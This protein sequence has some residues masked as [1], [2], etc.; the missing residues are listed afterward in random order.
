MSNW[1]PSFSALRAFDATARHLNF[2][3]A[4]E[5]LSVTPSAVKQ[6]VRKLEDSLGQPLVERDGRGLR[7][8]AAGEAGARRISEGFSS[9]AAGVAAIRAHDERQRL[10]LTVEPSFAATW[11]VPRLDRFR[12]VCPDVD[13]LVDSSPALV[14]LTK[15]TVD[16]A[17]RFSRAAP[18]GLVSRRLFDEELCAYCSPA[19]T[20]GAE[21]VLTIADLAR[22][23]L[24]H[25]DI[26]ALGWAA[27]TRQWM[28]W[29]QWL[30]KLGVTGIDSRRGPRFSDYYQAVQAAIAG[31]GVLLGSRLVMK[32]LIASNLL[33]TPFPEGVQTDLGYDVIA[34][35][36][37]AER[38]EV[39][40]FIEWI[41]A[42]ALT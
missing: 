16:I 5:E 33:V 31:Q 36:E 40:A 12:E 2:V 8:T 4:A 19:L 18:S 34:S 6:L 15:D 20:S 32:D 37:A 24:I 13:V 3:R 22:V 30:G 10:I 29:E 14:D 38:P 25:W 26:G 39:L 42:Q 35:R 9:I 11:L 17:I 27:E 7:L 28:G 23:P 41:E 1:M 21:P